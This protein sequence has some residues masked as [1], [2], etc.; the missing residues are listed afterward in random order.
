MSHILGPIDPPT[1]ASLRELGNVLRD[2]RAQRGLTQRALAGR[3]GLSQSTISRL[4][5]GLA[6]G[7]RVGW[8]ARLLAGLDQGVPLP[9]LEPWNPSLRVGWDLMRSRFHVRGPISASRI[10]T[11]R[12]STSRISTRSSPGGSPDPAV[13]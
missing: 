6:P 2:L 4:E 8:L 13:D 3:C 1:A 11:S 7:V 10:S 9:G 5:C 12:I